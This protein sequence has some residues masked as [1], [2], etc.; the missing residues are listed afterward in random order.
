MG[1]VETCDLRSTYEAEGNV[2]DQSIKKG[3]VISKTIAIKEA[4]E[5]VI[6]DR[7]HDQ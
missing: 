2:G 4:I 7:D 6:S 3:T 5:I 1:Q